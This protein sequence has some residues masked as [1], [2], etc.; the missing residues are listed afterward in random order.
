MENKGNRKHNNSIKS[1]MKFLIIIF[2]CSTL[3]N[4]CNMETET[5]ATKIFD[6]IYKI[7]NQHFYGEPVHAYLIELDDKFLLFDIPTYS[8]ELEKF[9]TSFK[10]P[11]YA[12]L[13]HGSCGISDGQKWQKKIGLKVYLHKGDETHPWLKMK[14]DSLF[15]KEPSFS[16][17]IKV[18]HTPGHSAG[19]VCIFETTTKTLFTGDTFQPLENGEIKDFTKQTAEKYENYT[20]RLSSCKKLS[21]LDFENVLPFH[22]SILLKSGKKSL[23]KFLTDK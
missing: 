18:I 21:E 16:D 19:S 14:P 1:A 8:E 15:E 12:I 9:I 23:L 10:K 17:N 5:L 7:N 6:N 13:S 4:A 3:A 2:T 11:S 20:D 22:Y